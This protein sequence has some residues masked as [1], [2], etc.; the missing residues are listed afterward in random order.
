MQRATKDTGSEAAPRELAR[1][2]RLKAIGLM[3][4][5]V[6]CF[7]GIDATGKFLITV[8]DLPYTQVVWVRFL[9]QF[10]VII[11]VLGAVS[12]P[13][14]LATRKWGPQLLRSSLLLASTALNFLALKE[15]R[16]DQSLSIQF[17]AP[18]VVA[19]LAGPFLGEWVGWRRMLAI[20]VGFC[21]VL[22]IVRP[23]FATVPTGIYF[24]FGCMLC[25]ACFMLLTRYL[26]AYDPP[27]VTLFCSLLVGTYLMAPL[28]VVDWEWPS[29]GWHW[30][31]I[32]TI[33]MW[34]ALGHYLFILAHRWAP[35]STIAP[36][37]YVQLLSMTGIG[38][39]VFGDLPDLW[40]LAGA[41]II[42][43]SGIYLI[44]RE[45]KVR[46]EVKPGA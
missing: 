37:L 35:A 11:V 23:G 44:F 12:V 14:L 39:F 22:V 33:G 5:A 24:A 10:L 9:G 20:V 4:L 42:V 6:T 18:L 27:E 26:A 43:A 40:T 15:L 7:S 19:L 21:G 25:Y 13:R 30:I 17:L 45:Q 29:V 28:A 46:G 16:L 3:C 1:T 32:I 2:N 41:A 36:F 8:A 31:L 38:Y 34:G